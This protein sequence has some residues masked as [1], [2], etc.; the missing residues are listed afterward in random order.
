MAEPTIDTDYA[1]SGEFLSKIDP[2]MLQ[3]ARYEGRGAAVS[4]EA[5]SQYI[6]GIGAKEMGAELAGERLKTREMADRASQIIGEKELTTRAAIA[7]K[8]YDVRQKVANEE[9]WGKLLGQAVHFG[10]NLFGV[11]LFGG[12]GGSQA[13]IMPTA[14]P[15]LSVP[16][17]VASS[18][19]TLNAIGA[20]PS[21]SL[22]MPS[23]QNPDLGL[24]K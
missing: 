19:Q 16:S 15:L 24:F 9:F 13:A 5:I 21:F 3:R 10:T 23:Q 18:M 4:P 20:N 1:L 7:Q 2:V 17:N 11:G 22:D 12:G 14:D 6:S 8:Q